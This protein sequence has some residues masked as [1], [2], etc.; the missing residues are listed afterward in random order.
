MHHHYCKQQPG[1]TQNISNPFDLLP[2][3]SQ[4]APSLSSKTSTWTWPR[5]PPVTWLESASL[6][7]SPART[8][9]ALAIWKQVNRKSSGE[10]C[11]CAAAIYHSWIICKAKNSSSV[12]LYPVS[13][14]R[15]GLDVS[16]ALEFRTSRTSGVLLAVSNQA[17]DGLGLEIVQDKVLKQWLKCPVQAAT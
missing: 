3:P 7:L 9:T 1:W 15:V 2:R 13:S 10:Y 8:L 14:Y 4:V 17:N 5:P 11:S 6:L 12:S 16:V